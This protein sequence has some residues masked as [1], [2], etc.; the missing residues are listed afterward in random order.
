MH[1]RQL[2][3]ILKSAL[4][5]EVEI[6]P[7]DVHVSVSGTSDSAN[8]IVTVPIEGRTRIIEIKAREIGLYEGLTTPTLA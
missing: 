3:Q 8:A 5:R 4:D 1:A 6:N 2:L 7:D